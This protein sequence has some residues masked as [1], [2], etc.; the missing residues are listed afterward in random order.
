MLVKLWRMRWYPM[1]P[2]WTVW[3][4][5]IDTNHNWSLSVWWSMA[6]AYARANM[7]Y[8]YTQHDEN[9]PSAAYNDAQYP[10]EF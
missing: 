2:V 1:V 6:I 4:K 10:K 3:W 5:W 7:N 8:S 9:D